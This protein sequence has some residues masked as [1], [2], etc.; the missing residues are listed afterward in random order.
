MI[1][2]ERILANI[3]LDDRFEVDGTVYEYDIISRERGRLHFGTNGDSLTEIDFIDT[4]EDFKQHLA[5][6]A[7]EK[8]TIPIIG[9][10]IGRKIEASRVEDYLTA[11]QY[12]HTG[13]NA[14]LKF[15]AGL[16][17]DYRALDRE[18]TQTLLLGM[19]RAAYS[20]V[21]ALAHFDCTGASD[22]GKNDL[23]N[24][25]VALIPPHYLE[26]F[27]TISPT[28]LQYETLVREIDGKVALT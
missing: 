28:A 27:S 6:R 7:H 13:E 23:V 15:C 2:N 17:F 21:S 26:L 3:P 9:A 10:H 5:Q 24:R 25:V 12:V 8:A 16:V 22:A 4:P 11:W 19:T 1:D 18:L 20:S 14:F